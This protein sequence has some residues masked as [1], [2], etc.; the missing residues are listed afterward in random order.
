MRRRRHFGNYA[1]RAIGH[2]DKARWVTEV[3]KT[4]K[5][6]RAVAKRLA[7]SKLG[8]YAP[9]VCIFD[10]TRWDRRPVCFRRRDVKGPK[11]LYPPK[12]HVIRYQPGRT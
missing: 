2:K 3:V 7:F 6:A 10:L 5:Q 4:A 1:V 9:T 12:I 11:Y 8:T